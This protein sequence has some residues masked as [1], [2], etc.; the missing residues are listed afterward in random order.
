[1]EHAECGGA[2][3]KRDGTESGAFAL[4]CTQKHVC[5]DKRVRDVD[6][7]VERFPRSRREP[8]EPEVV[9][10]CGECGEDEQRE[11]AQPLEGKAADAADI[12]SGEDGAE[13]EDACECAV[14]ER[15]KCGVEGAD[16]EGCN[17]EVSAVVEQW[18][19]DGPE[20]CER[21][22]GEGDVQQCE[23]ADGGGAKQ[24]DFV[25]DCLRRTM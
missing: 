7:H 21:S 23:A 22:D 12:A 15:G 11:H 1:M 10:G 25:G 20:A 5:G 4:H 2:D 6:E 17:A 13:R 14:E 18:G 8:L 24:Q 16:E 3:E 9:A 19:G